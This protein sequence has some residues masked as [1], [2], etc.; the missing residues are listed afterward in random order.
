MLTMVHNNR[1]HLEGG[2]FKVD[3]KFHVGMQSYVR[4]VRA[5]ILSVHPKSATDEPI[6]DPVE[7]PLEELGYSVMAL[8]TDRFMR[9]IP[10]ERESLRDAIRDS[11]LVYGGDLGS[12]QLA[13]EL[14]CALHSGA[15]VRP[16]NPD[17]RG[18]VPCSEHR[19][20]GREVCAMR[21]LVRA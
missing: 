10:G 13:R 16:S 12:A 20:P 1:V 4:D 21:T 7:I 17:Q 14:G 6:M 15:R 2:I 18:D 19:P 9:P 5:P 3:R 8:R 11:R